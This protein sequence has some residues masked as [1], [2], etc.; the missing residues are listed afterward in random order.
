M[1]IKLLMPALSPTMKEGNLMKWLKKEGDIIVSGDVIAEIETDKAIME[2]ESADSGV[3]GKIL[4]PEGTS[5]VKV[6]ELIAIILEDGE[7]ESDMEAILS[8]ILPVTNELPKQSNT[9]HQDV[10][11]QSLQQPTSPKK[12]R[13]FISP[14]AKK[15]ALENNV[16]IKA[17]KGSG[18]YSRIVKKDIEEFITTTPDN[19]STC[20][21]LSFTKMRAAIAERL[22]FSKKNIPH[23]YISIECCIDDLSSIRKSL[24]ESIKKSSSDRKISINDFFVKATALSLQKHN[25]FR[26]S[27]ENEKWTQHS[28]IDIAIAISI[29]DGLVTPVIRHSDQKSLMHISTEIVELAQKARSHSLRYNEISGGCITIS[30]LGMYGIKNFLPIINPPHVSIL[31]IGGATHKP[32]INTDGNITTSQVIEITLACDHRV[33]DGVDAALFINSI[34][35]Y[36]ENSMLLMM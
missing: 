28:A 16:D 23:F 25:K 12:E 14:I 27:F 26:S 19:N 32:T 17:V 8:A 33:I 11:T 22:S 3:L 21:T 20:T 5:N 18:P 34:K 9:E 36:I 29:E 35:F 4:I 2:F 1:P 24:N 30:N 6:K 10:K 13:I 15:L 7:S 31:A